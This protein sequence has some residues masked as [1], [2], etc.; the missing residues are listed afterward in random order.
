[1]R[2]QIHP[3]KVLPMGKDMFPS[4]VEVCVYVFSEIRLNILISTIWYHN[5]N[6][7]Y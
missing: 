4:E 7:K 6:M 1:M 5:T 2:L 3:T